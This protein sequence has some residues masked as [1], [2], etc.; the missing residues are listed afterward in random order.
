M[1]RQEHAFMRKHRCKALAQNGRQ[2]Q[3]GMRL[4]GDR[5]FVPWLTSTDTFT[6]ASIHGP[7][8]LGMFQ[9]RRL[10]ASDLADS[11]S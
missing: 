7:E 1:A 5:C 2:V 3:A 10:K 9:H 11:A 4:M 6:D 8:D